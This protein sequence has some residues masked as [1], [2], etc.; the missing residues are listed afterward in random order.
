MMKKCQLS[1]IMNQ[2]R[3]RYDQVEVG[4]RYSRYILHDNRRLYS[5]WLPNGSGRYV[6]FCAHAVWHVRELFSRRNEGNK[7]TMT[8]GN[9]EGFSLN[10]DIKPPAHTVQRAEENLLHL[11]KEIYGNYSEGDLVLICAKAVNTLRKVSNELPTS[12]RATW[13]RISLISLLT[14]AVFSDESESLLPFTKD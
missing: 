2:W 10:T 3:I 7:E 13:V 11:V 8:E 6:L 14:E 4:G 9:I 5:G 1:W 12:V